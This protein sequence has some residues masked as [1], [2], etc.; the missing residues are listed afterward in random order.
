MS[1]ATYIV[2]FAYNQWWMDLEGQA[3]GPFTS[4]EIAMAAA[5]SMAAAGSRAG[6]RT[7]VRVSEP[8][9]K[10]RVVYQSTAQSALV[11][12]TASLATLE[13]H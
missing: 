9:R 6:K 2:L 10:T 3:T 1:T 7:E 11:R 13:T 8:G 5:V 4:V 12:A